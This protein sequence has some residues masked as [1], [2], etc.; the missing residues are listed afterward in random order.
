MF[1]H[2]SLK[3]SNVDF[4]YFG[5]FAFLMFVR[6]GLTECEFMSKLYENRDHYGRPSDVVPKSSLIPDFIPVSLTL[7]GRN[8]PTRKEIRTCLHYESTLQGSSCPFV[9]SFCLTIKVSFF[10]STNTLRI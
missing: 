10:R 2:Y 5:Y 9:I 1:I 8:E 3:N 7:K 6:L 4:Q